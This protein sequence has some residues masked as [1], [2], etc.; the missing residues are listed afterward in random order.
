MRE[1]LGRFPRWKF[2]GSHATLPKQEIVE[3][4]ANFYRDVEAPNNHGRGRR[5]STASF[6][7]S[8]FQHQH[9]SQRMS[10]QP[11]LALEGFQEHGGL[12]SQ[13]SF[14]QPAPSAP[15]VSIDALSQIL[16]ASLGATQPS[17]PSQSSQPALPTG[18]VEHEGEEFTS[19]NELKEHCQDN[20][21]MQTLSVLLLIEDLGA[22]V[23]QLLPDI[24]R[25]EDKAKDS[26]AWEVKIGTV[27]AV[28]EAEYR[29]T[30]VIADD[31]RK[32]R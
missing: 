18:F 32:L 3:K 24:S 10:S 29:E 15:R 20:E 17:A 25:A 16:A 12:F 6:A 27:H 14:Q 22:E 4:F 30:V 19:W 8:T 23:S 26:T 1:E 2:A 21:D 9:A 5:G 13:S 28:K 7:S 11:Q 31:F